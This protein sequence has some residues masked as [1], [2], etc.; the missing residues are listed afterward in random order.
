MKKLNLPA[1]AA[2][3]VMI[4][5]LILSGCSHS[6]TSG[7]TQKDSYERET[8]TLQFIINISDNPGKTTT[9]FEDMGKATKE[10]ALF[11]QEANTLLFDDHRQPEFNKSLY[12]EYILFKPRTHIFELPTLYARHGRHIQLVVGMGGRN[13]SVAIMCDGRMVEADPIA[14]NRSAWAIVA[15]PPAS[16]DVF[17]ISYDSLASG[18]SVWIMAAINESLVYVPAYVASFEMLYEKVPESGELFQF[19]VANPGDSESCRTALI[20]TPEIPVPAGSPVLDWEGK[21][22]GFTPAATIGLGGAK[23]APLEYILKP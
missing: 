20:T 17:E 15:K 18:D 13:D 2:Y 14:E 1:K 7:V 3:C 9:T 23:W 5:F 8:D 10:A 11:A 12:W 22:V 16:E 6:A 4:S 21:L 19:M